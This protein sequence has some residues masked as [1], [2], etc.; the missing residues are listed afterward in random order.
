[1]P[2][3]RRVPYINKEFWAELK[4]ILSCCMYLYLHTLSVLLVMFNP[5]LC[6][7]YYPTTDF[8]HDQ[9]LD[10]TPK[11]HIT[12]IFVIIASLTSIISHT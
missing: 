3:L 2:S 5:T 7:T 10:M 12:D 11:F 6:K 9:F 4:N 1:M 8:A